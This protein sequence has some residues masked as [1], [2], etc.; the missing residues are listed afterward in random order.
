MNSVRQGLIPFTVYADLMAYIGFLSCMGFVC[1][2]ITSSRLKL[3]DKV[4]ERSNVVQYIGHGYS[5]NPNGYHII[6][7][8]VNEYHICTN[9]ISAL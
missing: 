1:R 6:M 2:K 7:I 9:L 8:T 5:I 3:A 4:S